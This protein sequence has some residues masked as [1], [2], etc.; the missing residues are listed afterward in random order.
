MF[1][2]RLLEFFTHIH[3][4]VPIVTAVP[5]IAY[6]VH[7][8]IV[9][10]GVDVPIVA[11]LIAGGVLTWTLVEYLMHRFIF[12]HQF[13]SRFGQRVYFVIHGSHHDYPNDASRILASPAFTIPGGLAFYGAFTVLFGPAYAAGAFAGLASGYLAYEVMHYAAH[14]FPMNRGVWRRLKQR[15]LRHHYGDARTGFGV[16]SPLWDYVFRTMPD[17]SK[18][19]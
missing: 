9:V 15:H 5:V 17:E 16:S 19:R 13:R 11:A 2:S 12:H 1:E 18:N 14:R 3:P 4:L 8:S 10:L 6:T 7:R